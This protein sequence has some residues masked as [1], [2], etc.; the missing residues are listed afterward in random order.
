M[1]CIDCSC[2]A[3][4]PVEYILGH[5]RFSETQ[6]CGE[7]FGFGATACGGEPYEP[8]PKWNVSLPR[9]PKPPL[10][11]FVQPPVRSLILPATAL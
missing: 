10:R 11:P 8:H 6:V 9:T 3:Q 4:P 5:M 1:S 7:V 2:V